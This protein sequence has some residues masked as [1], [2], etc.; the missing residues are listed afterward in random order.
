M[1]DKRV[2]WWRIIELTD[3]IAKP[4]QSH[5]LCDRQTHIGEIYRQTKLWRISDLNN[6]SKVPY[7]L[8]KNLEK[9]DYVLGRIKGKRT[10]HK[11]LQVMKTI[12]RQTRALYDI[13]MNKFIL[14]NSELFKTFSYFHEPQRTITWTVYYGK[15]RWICC[16]SVRTSSCYLLSS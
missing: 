7:L 10:F 8:S 16:S 13:K 15:N 5:W 14:Y 4:K 12:K 11:A 6:C 9:F 1:H 2:N 3:L